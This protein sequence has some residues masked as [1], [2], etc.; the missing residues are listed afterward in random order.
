MDL[1]IKKFS[2]IYYT[3]EKQ[4]SFIKLWNGGIVYDESTVK[5]G[6]NRT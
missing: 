4:Y 5:S 2:I 6:P 1:L 3:L